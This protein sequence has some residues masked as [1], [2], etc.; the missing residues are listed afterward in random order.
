MG[1]RE[2]AAKGGGGGGEKY[3]FEK[4]Q[5]FI[6]FFDNLTNNII[7]NVI[8][9]CN[10]RKYCHDPK[11]RSKMLDNLAFKFNNY[12]LY[13]IYSLNVCTSCSAKFAMKT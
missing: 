4:A 8:T 13:T 1:V 6:L 7:T 5:F 12:L 9:G 10:K 2:Q 11:S 3:W